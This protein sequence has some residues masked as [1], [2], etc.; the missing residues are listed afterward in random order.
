MP[1]LINQ[2]SDVD[3]DIITY[4][5][6]ARRFNQEAESLLNKGLRK[7]FINHVEETNRLRGRVLMNQSMSFIM[8]NKPA[9]VCEMDVYSINIQLNQIFKTTLESIY[10][11][12]F[13]SENVRNESFNIWKTVRDVNFINLDREIFQR[14][15]FNRLTVKYKPIIHLARLLYELILLSHKSGEW[16]LFTAKLDDQSMNNLFEKFLYG[17]YQ[18]EQDQYLVK[19]EKIHWKLE[20]NA[21]Y[22]PSMK[23]DVSMIHK[24][25]KE[26]IIIDAKFY[27]NMFQQYYDKSSFHSHNLYQMF[28]YLMHQPNDMKVKGILIYPQNGYMVNETYKW[29]ENVSVKV[30][31]INLDSSWNTIYQELLSEVTPF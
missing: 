16:D 31:S 15:R 14:I 30:I 24:K 17:F 21:R 27:K 22:L 23:T 4:D 5:F 13:V 1:E 2:L 19:S 26:K 3:E 28:S 29:N 6:I 9:L 25:N 8:E 20:G 10:K 18:A 11:N 12:H 7:D